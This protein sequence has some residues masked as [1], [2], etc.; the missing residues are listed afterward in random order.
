MSLTIFPFSIPFH[1][2]F[3]YNTLIGRVLQK[4]TAVMERRGLLMAAGTPKIHALWGLVLPPLP[5]PLPFPLSPLPPRPVA[6][7][8][9]LALEAPAAITDAVAA[10]QPMYH[11]P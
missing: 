1:F 11:L 4:L 8:S 2:I 10:V 5:F 6:P 7:L 3:F 9:G